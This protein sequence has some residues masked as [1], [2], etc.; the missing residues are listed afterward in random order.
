M[1]ALENRGNLD[2][3]RKQARQ[4][5]LDRYDVRKVLPLQLDVL[6]RVTRK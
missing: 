1:E 5:V 6:R 2:G 4:T 3:M